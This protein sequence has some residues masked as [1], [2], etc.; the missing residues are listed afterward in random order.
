VGPLE[1]KGGPSYRLYK[2]KEKKINRREAP[3]WECGKKL[4]KIGV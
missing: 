2:K 3:M 1:K 4:R